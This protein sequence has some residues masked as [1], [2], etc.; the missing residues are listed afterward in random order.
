MSNSVIF[1]VSKEEAKVMKRIIDKC[2][3]KTNLNKESII[4]EILYA[5]SAD[6]GDV[7][8]YRIEWLYIIDC[9]EDKLKQKKVQGREDLEDM[10]HSLKKLRLTAED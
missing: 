9:Y 1:N 6:N 10:L 5:V 7:Q 8:L 2:R 4:D 3:I